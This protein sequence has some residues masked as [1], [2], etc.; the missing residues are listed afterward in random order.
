MQW[1]PENRPCPICDATEYVE[2]G[3]RGGKSHRD[4]LGEE[5]MVVKCT[6]CTG[7]YCYPTLIPQGNPYDDEEGYFSMHSEEDVRTAATSTLEYFEKLGKKGRILELGCGRGILSAVA[8]ERGWDAKGVEMT[9]QFVEEAIRHGV[10]VEVATVEDCRSLDEKY[11]VIL[12]PAILEHLYRPVDVLKRIN[13]A[14]NPGG[15]LFLDIP[16]EDSLTFQIGNLYSR[17]WSINLS[18]TFSPYHVV[19][20]SPASI[21]RALDISGFD[22]HELST[23]KYANTLPGGSIRRNLERFVM[24]VSLHVGQ[25]IGRGDGLLVWAVKR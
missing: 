20:F 3:T 23:V 2:I 6:N 15:M 4:R 24:G 11:D 13:N 5:T 7:I 8:K 9:V 16:N 25:W 14:L 1:Y 12:M 18:P 22:I 21:R 10:E 19:G 17:P